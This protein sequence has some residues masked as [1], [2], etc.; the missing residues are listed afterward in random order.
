MRNKRIAELLLGILIFGVLIFGCSKAQEVPAN[1]HKAE[2]E[3]AEEEALAEMIDTDVPIEKGTR[4]AVVAKSTVGEF[5]DNIKQG[6]ED[7][8]SGLNEAYGLEGDD[9]I[10]MTFEGPDNE[11]DLTDLINTVD[12]VLAE[13]P[14]VLCLASGDEDAGQAQLETARDNGIPVILFDSLVEVDDDTLYA[15]YCGSDNR[16]MGRDA[17]GKLTEAMNGAGKVAVI[18]HWKNDRTSIERT[19]G[20]KEALADEAPQVELAA[21]LVMEED[22]DLSEQVAELLEEVPDLNGIYCTNGD[23]AEAVLD[24]LKDTEEHGIQVVGT[25]GTSRQIDAIEAGEELG[26][27][28]QDPYQMGFQTI[29]TAVRAAGE[30][31]SL[32]EKNIYIDHAWL[33]AGNLEEEG[34]T[35]YIYG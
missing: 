22:R 25:D 3:E 6:M 8:V 30:P 34:S 9:K 20:F 13:N 5:W 14:T 33:D 31:Q 17:A 18:S 2:A 12:A 16:E 26:A 7:A 1:S 4:I 35:S 15:A 23:A 32:T 10:T 19:A 11:G 29:C 27:V 24:A 28:S 21:E